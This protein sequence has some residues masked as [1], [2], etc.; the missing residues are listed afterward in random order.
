MKGK[1]MIE[2]IRVKTTENDTGIKYDLMLFNDSSS[3]EVLYRIRATRDIHTKFG[4]V[5]KGDFGGVV[6]SYHN[7]NKYDE[8][9]IFENAK[10][11]GNATVSG[12]SVVRGNAIVSG[13]GFSGSSLG[14]DQKTVIENNAV[15]EGNAQII[16]HVVIVGNVVIKDSV[17]IAGNMKCTIHGN[18]TIKNNTLI[19]RYSFIEG[20]NILIS[21]NSSLMDIVHIKGNNIKIHN[22]II[23][24]NL[25]HSCPILK[26][27]MVNNAVLRGACTLKNCVVNNTTVQNANIGNY[28]CIRSSNDYLVVGPIGSRDDF[29]TFYLTK[30]YEIMVSCGCFN[31]TI[32]KFEMRVKETHEGNPLYLTQY[33]GIIQYVKSV[34]K[35]NKEIMTE[36][37]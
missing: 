31:D 10:V 35:I 23:Q 37:I 33:L 29:T 15:I 27:V 19:T 20:N 4:I 28:G 11:V 7:L 16:G 2:D 9:W 17:R 32:D 5:H 1:E 25:Y 22:T 24:G 6:E 3:N 36:S 26:N 34:M 13:Y 30:D 14:H 21:G 18:I 8:S 12:N